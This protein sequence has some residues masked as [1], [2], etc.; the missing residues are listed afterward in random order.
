VLLACSGQAGVVLQIGQNYSAGSTPL[1]LP[2]AG[3]AV[4]TNHIVQFINGRFSVLSKSTGVLLQSITARSFWTNAGVTMPAGVF[5]ATPRVLFDWETQR[6]VALMVDVPSNELNNRFLLAISATDDPTGPWHG[7]AFPADLS[8]DYFADFPALG[9]DASGVYVSADIFD[10]RG[11]AVGSTL[12]S[13]PKSALLNHPPSPA[14]RTASSLLS[15]TQYGTVLQPAVAVGAASTE[16]VVLAVGD[17]GYDFQPHSNLVAV[18]VHNAGV[19]GAAVLGRPVN[20][21]VPAYSVPFNAAQPGVT[22]NI[23][24]GDARFS[25]TVYRVGDVVYATHST[26]VNNRAA[27][28]WFKIEAVSLNVMDSGII[29]DP[30]LDLYYPSIGANQDGVVVMV[31]NGSSGSTFISSYAILGETVNGRLQFGSMVLLKAGVASYRPDSE[32][33]PW[34]NYSAIVMDPADSTHFWA[35]TMYAASSSTWATQITE[36]IATPLVLSISR[37]GA[38]M[39]LSWPGAATEYQLQV[40]SNLS[41]TT[42]ATIPQ[43]PTLIHDRFTVSLESPGESQFFRL[44]KNLR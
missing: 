31:F 16:E 29:H 42:W 21:A 33:N 10:A 17:L 24:D 22:D 8:D 14:G 44:I 41:S 35:L 40:K 2:D 32:T 39:L 20:I 7:V 19:A 26:E 11:R 28:Q 1:A 12:V 6:W 9:I 13:I 27:I 36:L 5:P 43:P 18:T 38:S 30:V 23:D 4:S 37:L 34:G 15:Y 25:A 3:L